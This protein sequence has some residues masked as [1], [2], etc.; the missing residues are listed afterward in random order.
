MRQIDGSKIYIVSY[1]ESQGCWDIERA[2]LTFDRNETA[3]L[4]NKFKELPSYQPLGLFPTNTDA[5]EYINTF[6]KVLA[7]KNKKEE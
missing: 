1:C 7:D 4:R 5:T 3:L 2:D 6:K